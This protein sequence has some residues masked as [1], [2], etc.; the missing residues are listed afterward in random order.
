M[1]CLI[2]YTYLRLSN[3]TA[4]EKVEQI[5]NSLTESHQWVIISENEDEAEILRQETY[6]KEHAW[7]ERQ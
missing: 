6:N 7:L 3:K 5:R 2:L 4:N 1:D